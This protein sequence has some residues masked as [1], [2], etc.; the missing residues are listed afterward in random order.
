[1][2]K[3]PNVGRESNRQKQAS[4]YARSL[5][6]ASLD[7]LLAINPEGKITDVNEAT[8]KITGVGREHLIGTDFSDY[9]TEPDQA[10]AGYRKAFVE[11]SVANYPLTIRALDGTLTDVL[12]NASVYQ[13]TQ[14][15]VLGVFATTRDRTELEKAFL[16]RDS[17]EQ[18]QM[19][20]NFFN[21]TAS[22]HE[23]FLLVNEIGIIVYANPAAETLFAFA[24]EKML[25][26][27]V[28]SLIPS[29]FR[30]DHP[31][32]RDNYFSEPVARPMG[33]GQELSARRNDGTEVPVEI[34]LTP[35]QTPTGAQVAVTIRDITEQRQAARYARD[36][37]SIIE[38]SNDSITSGNMEG[39]VTSWNPASERLFGYCA[40]EMIGQPF[41][42][43][44]GPEHTH[45]DTDNLSK[46][47]DGNKIEAYETQRIRKDGSTIP[48]SLTISPIFDENGAVIGSSGIA[49]DITS[50]KQ[51][52][53]QLE[54]MNDL[55][56][57]FVAV[58]AHDLR[59]PAASISGFAHLL[60]DE[61]DAI[62]D[63]KKIENLRIITRNTDAL[64]EFVENVLQVARIEAGEFTYQI[65]SFNIRALAQRTVNE[66]IGPNN[67]RR[68]ELITPDALPLVLGDEERQWQI[69]TNLLSNALKF[70]PAKEPIV[71]ELSRI[72]DWVQVAVTDRGI[73]I[74]KDDLVKMFRKS[75]RLL[76]SGNPI[77]PGNG[78]GLFICKTLVEAQGG[79]IWCE[80]TPG[81][82]STFFFTIPV[83]R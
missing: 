49:R 9:F 62:D 39:I 56:N 45:E 5:I 11:G 25:G 17:A 73:G 7:P 51:M 77:I 40:A 13:D 69:L 16:D 71:V 76:T 26:R 44:W 24:R 59:A 21:V 42:R 41:S 82:G 52:I 54:E 20:S 74:A 10:C 22:H 34:S 8:V 29:R 37:A 67:D 28:E 53:R 12:Y 68:V 27:A 57:E 80:S 55:R 18:R 2:E 23:A 47:R 4:Q 15:N 30:A 14:G 83:A 48:I 6:E 60:I 75:E 1:M 66:S 43:L 46:I 58:I 38:S 36:M 32:L 78:L 63:E 3:Q 61:W 35:I 72:G 79:R 31:G 65:S 64:V 50:E 33:K 81:Q 19:E 70:S